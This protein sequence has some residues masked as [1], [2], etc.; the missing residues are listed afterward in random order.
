MLNLKLTFDLGWQQLV[1][2][3]F[4]ILHILYLKVIWTESMFSR[5][6]NGMNMIN[7]LEY[8]IIIKYKIRCMPQS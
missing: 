2:G 6:Y 7:F 1:T 4:V 3:S 5:V 8:K